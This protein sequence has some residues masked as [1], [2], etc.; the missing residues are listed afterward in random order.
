MIDGN[1]KF[2]NIFLDML[3]TTLESRY[4]PSLKIH[5][6]KTYGFMDQKIQ[7]IDAKNKNPF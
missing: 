4:L 5:F 2:G 3:N 7:P 6:D 1:G